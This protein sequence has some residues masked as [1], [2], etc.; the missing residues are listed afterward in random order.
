MTK[1]KSY[2]KYPAELNRRGLLKVYE[3][4]VTAKVFVQN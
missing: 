3:D 1:G 2:E 4:G